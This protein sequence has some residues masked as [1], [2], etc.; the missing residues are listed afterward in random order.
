MNFLEKIKEN[1]IQLDLERNQL[2]K[3][4]EEINYNKENDYLYIRLKENNNYQLNF[5]EFRI[6][7]DEY[8]IMIYDLLENNQISE[9]ERFSLNYIQ[10][11]DDK[12]DYIISFLIDRFFQFFIIY[13]ENE[14]RIEKSKKYNIERR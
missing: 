4:Y 11:E 12:F 14:Y 9:I 2:D 5:K 13:L 1:L 7:F 3:Y 8:N 10:F 6:I